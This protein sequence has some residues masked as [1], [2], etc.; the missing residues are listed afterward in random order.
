MRLCDSLLMIE[1]EIVLTTFSLSFQ[2]RNRQ[3]I[4]TDGLREQMLIL[5]HYVPI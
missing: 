1:V 5:A 4:E 2:S 3:S